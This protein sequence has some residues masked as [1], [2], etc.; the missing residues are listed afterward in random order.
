MQYIR[1]EGEGYAYVDHPRRPAGANIDTGIGVDRIA[2][3]LQGVDNV[4]ET[5]LLRPVLDRAVQITARYGVTTTA[6]FGCA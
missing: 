2:V 1:G 3:L 6:T 5:D 4:F